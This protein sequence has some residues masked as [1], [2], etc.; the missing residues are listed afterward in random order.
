MSRT[1]SHCVALVSHMLDAVTRGRLAELRRAL[2]ATHDVVLTLTEP[3]GAQAASL[4]IGNVEVL[5]P[6]EIFLPEYGAKSASRSV[7][8]G[9][10]DLIVLALARRRPGYRAIWMVE[11]DV[12]FAGGAELLGELDAASSAELICS[13]RL[14]NRVETPD[15][16]WWPTLQVAPSEPRGG[17]RGH[18]LLCLARYGTPLLAALDA[19]Y[20][21]GWNGHFEAVVPTLA[22]R[23][24]L[25]IES[26][27]D[28]ARR[29][30]GHPVLARS[31]FHPVR[32]RA[33][34]GM[35]IYHPVKTPDAEAQ[36][37]RAI[38]Q[39]A[40]LA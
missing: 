6:D 23:R 33:S 12:M 34:A 4:G 10:N 19:A 17:P 5:S 37:R 36:L 2:S 32:C 15:W 40:A 11:Y 18:A 13:T 14:R 7:V 1:A 9:N 30:L 21:A 29:A 20:R 39:Q 26:L 31:S 27:N 8:P 3:L 28:I 38:R 24:D 16:Y 22:R 25:P 35:R